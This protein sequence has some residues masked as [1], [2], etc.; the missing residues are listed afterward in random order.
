MSRAPMV[1]NAHADRCI[2]LSIISSIQSNYLLHPRHQHRLSLGLLSFS[3]V[4]AFQ[5]P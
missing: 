2:T 3:A 1:S 4:V 5:R